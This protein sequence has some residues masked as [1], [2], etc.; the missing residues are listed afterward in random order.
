MY[1]HGGEYRKIYALIAA[2]GRAARMK[3]AADGVNKVYLDLN[4]FPVLCYSLDK[5]INTG[6]ID[7]VVIVVSDH[8]GEKADNI[9]NAIAAPASAVDRN[10]F[11]YKAAGGKTRG[12]SIY[13]GL[14]KIMEIAGGNN[15]IDGT[16]VLIHDA[17]RPNFRPADLN[18]ALKMFF[19]DNDCAGV[20]FASPSRDTLCKIGGDDYIEGY[21]DRDKIFKISTPQIFCLKKLFNC[22]EKFITQ[23]GKKDDISFTDESSLMR[24]CGW[25]VKIYRCP[26]DNIK[27]TTV[28]DFDY[29]KS[30]IRPAV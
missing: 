22:F 14:K 13:N 26:A 30:I 5:F 2:A 12:G 28:E 17:A 24:A 9:I 21:E 27:I 16:A 4:G 25:K 3:G 6:Y 19:D 7:A 10:P 18:A 11:L 20:T 15:E 8:D 1:I 29:L 23:N